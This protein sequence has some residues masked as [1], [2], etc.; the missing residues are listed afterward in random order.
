MVRPQMCAVVMVATALRQCVE[1]KVNMKRIYEKTKKRRQ[2]MGRA[3]QCQGGA[4]TPGPATNV[5]RR[6]LYSSSVLSSALYTH[7]NE[8][9]TTYD[10]S[11]LAD[12]LLP[13][14]SLSFS[15]PRPL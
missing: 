14:P 6:L 3:S 9:N 10:N 1:K 2:K 7:Y 5:G 4:L 8:Y 13:L 11:T 12:Y 15:W